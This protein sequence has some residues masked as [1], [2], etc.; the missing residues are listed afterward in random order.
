MMARRRAQLIEVRRSQNHRTILN[1]HFDQDESNCSWLLLTLTRSRRSRRSVALGR[2]RSRSVALGRARSR[3]D[4]RE[5]TD[6]DRSLVDEARVVRSRASTNPELHRNLEGRL[7]FD[8]HERSHHGRLVVVSDE[9]QPEDPKTKK[10]RTTVPAL[11][12]SAYEISSEG[13][14]MPVFDVGPEPFNLARDEDGY[15]ALLAPGERHDVE[16]DGGESRIPRYIPYNGEFVCS[17]CKGPDKDGRCMSMDAYCL[18]FQLRENAVRERD[19]ARLALASLQAENAQLRLQL[20]TSP[21]LTSTQTAATTPAPEVHG[22]VKDATSV[23][24]ASAT[25]ASRSRTQQLA[26]QA[27]ARLAK[28]RGDVSSGL[29]LTRDGIA[30]HGNELLRAFLGA[31]KLAVRGG[32]AEMQDRIRTAFDKAQINTW[33]AGDPALK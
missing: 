17:R 14:W 19:E 24:T 2:A 7:S 6:T 25:G 26:I 30:Q 5:V 1:Q 11:N 28:A 21:S 3:L 33:K 32:K 22:S 27:A 15:Y 18:Q 4:Q 29:L 12:S 31:M 8:P 10:R 9:F 23:G 20:P 13:R 16:Y